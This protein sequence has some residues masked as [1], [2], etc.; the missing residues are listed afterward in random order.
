MFLFNCEDV[1][2]GYSLDELS[3]VRECLSLEKIK[4]DYKIVSHS[5]YS[6]GRF[7]SLGIN[8]NYEKQYNVYVKRKDYKKAKYLVEKTLH[9]L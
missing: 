2:I 7:G 1:Y 6:R 5:S 4:Y 3:K 9:R 8:M